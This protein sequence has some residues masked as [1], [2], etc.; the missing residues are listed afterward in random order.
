MEKRLEELEKEELNATKQKITTKKTALNKAKKQREKV[1]KGKKRPPVNKK[2]EIE[3][4]Q[5]D[6]PEY[7]D[8]EGDE[9]CYESDEFE[10]EM[11]RIRSK[12]K[13]NHVET[14]DHHMI[15]ADKYD[16]EIE[17]KVSSYED[18]FYATIFLY[19]KNHINF[20]W[21][22]TD[23]PLKP[24][25]KKHAEYPTVS[26]KKC[27]Y[28][29]KTPPFFPIFIPKSYDCMKKVYILQ[30]EP[31]CSLG[32]AKITIIQRNKYNIG[33]QVGL[34]FSFARK[35]LGYKHDSIPFVPLSARE[36]YSY[37]GTMTEKEWEEKKEQ[38][39]VLVQN[40]P[41][42]FV[43]TFL[44]EHEIRKREQEKKSLIQQNYQIGPTSEQQLK[45][46]QEIKRVV[47]NAKKGKVTS[48][49]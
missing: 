22:F 12:E 25:G 45:Y 28:C 13:E 31:F 9:K 3:T 34:L 24:V 42:L 14:F 23:D 49:K 41:V 39:C 5:I 2:Q 37:Y 43:E 36:D 33:Q 8:D 6:L 26:T 19:K 30:R 38:S 4:P 16:K 47:E 1:A 15:D 21:K 18:N 46:T 29:H 32:C 20:L 35:F 17:T 48:D 40:P 10:E 27:L 7:E 11:E 44:E